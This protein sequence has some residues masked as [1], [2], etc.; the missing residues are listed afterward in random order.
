MREMGHKEG[1]D[2]GD[3]RIIRNQAMTSQYPLRIGVA[4]ENGFPAGIKKDAVGR[5]RADASNVEEF[6]PEDG[7]RLSTHH[8]NVSGILLEE[9]PDERLE[10]LCLDVIITGRPDG[11]G[12]DFF[13]N[14]EQSG[15]REKISVL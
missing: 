12:Q 11:F 8:L 7:Q 4:D 13:I 6:F 3:V 9:K 5:F 10:P 15:G 1:P 2:L 14:S